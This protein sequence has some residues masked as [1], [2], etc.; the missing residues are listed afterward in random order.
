MKR[1]LD[2][3]IEERKKK[4]KSEAKKEPE[5]QK[6]MIEEISSTAK[7]TTSQSKDTTKKKKITD[8]QITKAAALAAQS[9]GKDYLKRPK[10][11]Y[12][13]ESIWRSY[14]DDEEKLCTFLYESIDPDCFAILFKENEI[15]TEVYLS[16]IKILNSTFKEYF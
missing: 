15:P 3:V 6:K 5:E 8:E 1:V 7:A 13:F 16:L 4:L 2:I 9:L 14:K 10:T 12:A 11:A